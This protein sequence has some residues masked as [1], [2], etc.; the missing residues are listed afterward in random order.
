[1]YSLRA[2]PLRKKRFKKGKNLVRVL[3]AFET[4]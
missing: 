1:M 4:I 2:V 3:Y